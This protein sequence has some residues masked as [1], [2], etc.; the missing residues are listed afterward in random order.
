MLN[1]LKPLVTRSHFWSNYLSVT[2]QEGNL[3]SR[4]QFSRVRRRGTISA[5]AYRPRRS[6]N[7]YCAPVNLPYR[8]TYSWRRTSKMSSAQVNQARSCPLTDPVWFQNQVLHVGDMCNW[9]CERHWV[10]EIR[11]S[12]KRCEETT[13]VWKEH[14]P[15]PK[16]TGQL[17]VGVQ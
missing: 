1:C 15:D 11:N 5:Q 14:L 13:K 9:Q 10:D 8:A 6:H 16:I 4:Y 2:D 12:G 17:K 3:Q 7:C